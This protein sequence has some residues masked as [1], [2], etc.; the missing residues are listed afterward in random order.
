MEMIN[1]RADISA[2]NE[3]GDSVI[4]S[5][6][7]GRRKDKLELLLTLLINSEIDVN[8]QNSKGDTAL[9]IAIQV[10]A[11]IVAKLCYFNTATQGVKAVFP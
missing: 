4:H 9:H 5:I 11:S 6:L 10:S 2:L 1:S 3:E 8:C 7:W